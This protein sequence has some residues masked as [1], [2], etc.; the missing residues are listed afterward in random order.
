VKDIEG[1]LLNPEIA[2]HQC[3]EKKAELVYLNYEIRFWGAQE[4][5]NLFFRSAKELAQL[6]LKR[7]L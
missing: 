7:H 3:Q 2:G 4:L 5:L 6:L 1:A